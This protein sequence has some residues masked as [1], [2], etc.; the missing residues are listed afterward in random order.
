ME[1]MRD[2]TIGHAFADKTNDAFLSLSQDVRSS[3][4]DRGRGSSF[5]QIVDEIKHLIRVNPN[6][7]LLHDINALA[8]LRK[9]VV[10]R[11]DAMCTCLQSLDNHAS[12]DGVDQNDHFCLRT[13][14][15]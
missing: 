15:A 7:S 12:C 13:R 3:D 9:R 2:C 11:D 5:D 4:T 14:N 6:L 1:L 8:E 10:F